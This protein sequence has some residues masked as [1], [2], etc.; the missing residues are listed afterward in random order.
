MRMSSTNEN[1]KL[2]ANLE[3]KLEDSDQV[4]QP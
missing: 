1:L 4:T 2:E 3:Y